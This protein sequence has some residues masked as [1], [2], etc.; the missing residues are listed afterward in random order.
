MKILEL[1]NSGLLKRTD[2]NNN[3]W[4]I[5]AD[6]TET[7]NNKVYDSNTGF[8]TTTIEDNTSTP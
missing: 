7:F 3:V 2:Y 6:G 5:N 8:I 1:D 4:T